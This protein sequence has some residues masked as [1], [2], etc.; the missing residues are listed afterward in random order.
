MF[1]SR[2]G[3]ASSISCSVAWTEVTA[4]ITGLRTDRLVGLVEESQRALATEA[5]RGPIDVQIT[6]S[7]ALTGGDAVATVKS[8]VL[9]ARMTAA[10]TEQAITVALPSATVTVTPALVAAAQ[11]GTETPITLASAQP[12]TITAEP[13]TIPKLLRAYLTLGA[14]ICG[15]PALDQQFKTVDF[16]TLL[17]LEALPPQARMRFLG[18]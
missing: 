13:V 11:T 1:A 4:S 15:P 16:L 5:L 7:G 6:K 12:V 9:D 18:V 10:I 8:P 2:T 14:K 3:I 17:D